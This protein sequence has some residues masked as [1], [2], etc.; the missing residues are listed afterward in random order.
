MKTYRTILMV[1]VIAVFPS[2]LLKAQT[3][4]FTAKV[5]KDGIQRVEIKGGSYYYDPNHIIVKVNVP[6]EL[7]IKK[8]KGMTPHD[9]NLKAPD[10]GIDFSESLGK[11]SK[12]IKFTPTKTGK[13]EFY[14]SKKLP[15]AKGHREKGMEG[16]LEVRD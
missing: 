16:I 11:D 5:D 3:K 15:F 10:A 6:V 4:E 1:F 7:N 12:S 14:C 9:I 13:Y 8:E 2:F